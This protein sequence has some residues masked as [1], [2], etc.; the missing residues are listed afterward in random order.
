MYKWIVEI[1]ISADWVADGF[2]LSSEDRIE[3]LKSHLLPY[4]YSDE[5]KIKILKSPKL[6]EI[7]TEQGF[8]SVASTKLA[9]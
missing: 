6:S 5:S 8:S 1:E 2:N 9:S 7:A 3:A 4:G